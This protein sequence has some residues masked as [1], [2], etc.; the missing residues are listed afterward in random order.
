MVLWMRAREWS[1]QKQQVC[2]EGS[3]VNPSSQGPWRCFQV[4]KQS[5]TLA[6]ATVNEGSES[7]LRPGLSDSKLF[8]FQGIFPFLLCMCF[9]SSMK[10]FG[11][12]HCLSSPTGTYHVPTSQINSLR[13]GQG[14]CLPHKCGVPSLHLSNP[15]W[16][17][18]EHLYPSL[19]QRCGKQ[20]GLYTATSKGPN[21]EQGGRQ[22]LTP[23][24]VLW[25][26]HVHLHMRTTHSQERKKIIK[27]SL[28]IFEKKTKQK[29]QKWKGL[30]CEIIFQNPS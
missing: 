6:N 18:C 11:Y 22:G 2:S 13:W 7:D 10:T 4:C 23:E 21:L 14:K 26:P 29:K 30:K 16:S 8:S 25:L 24:A 1:H 17:C 15:A 27:R 20:A 3:C 12:G 5:P 9:F 19:L 28:C